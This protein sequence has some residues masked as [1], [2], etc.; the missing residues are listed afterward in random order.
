MKTMLIFS[1]RIFT[2]TRMKSTALVG[3]ATRQSTKMKRRPRTRIRDRH[4]NKNDLA[5]N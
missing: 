2:R 4:L 5:L 3:K 1:A